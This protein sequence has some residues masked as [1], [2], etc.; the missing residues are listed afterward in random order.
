MVRILVSLVANTQRTGT[1]AS[2]A[3]DGNGW[4]VECLSSF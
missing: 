4:F 1:S 3:V 2:D